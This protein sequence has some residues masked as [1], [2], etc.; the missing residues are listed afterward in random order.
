MPYFES[1]AYIYV[2]AD[3]SARELHPDERQYLESD[4]LP[5]DGAAPSIKRDY[6]QRNGWGEIS[7]YLERSKLPK[8]TAIKRAPK[9]NPSR[10]LNKEAYVEWLLSKGM[11]VIENGDGSFVISDPRRK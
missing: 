4:F 9:K 5:G 10:A 1:Y 8:G 3:G 7:G 11:R 2:N 6:G